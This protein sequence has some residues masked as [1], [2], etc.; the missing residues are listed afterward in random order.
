VVIPFGFSISNPNK[1]NRTHT[2]SSHNNNNNNNNNRISHKEIKV[3]K[4]TE[5]AIDS[6]V[7]GAACDCL[8]INSIHG[9]TK[10]YACQF[11]WEE[12]QFQHM[13]QPF[14]EYQPV[15]EVKQI[16]WFGTQKGIPLIRLVVTDGLQS[17]EMRP[18]LRTEYVQR[19]NFKKSGHLFSGKLNV[20]KRFTLLEYT[21]DNIECTITNQSTPTI[22]FECIPAQPQKKNMKSLN[23]AHANTNTKS[24]EGVRVP[25]VLDDMEKNNSFQSSV[26]EMQCQLD[27]L[28]IH[29]SRLGY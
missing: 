13:Q 10:Y 15:L 18:S 25:M 17:M 8:D 4:L 6:L 12:E 28:K 1:Q 22:F 24:T 27:R 5:G 3:M 9:N 7:A 14:P 23:R 2:D 21:T 16:Q 20:G 19:R 26:R 11:I 29:R